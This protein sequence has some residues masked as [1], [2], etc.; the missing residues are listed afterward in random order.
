[1]PLLDVLKKLWV[2]KAMGTEGSPRRPT[3]WFGSQDRFFEAPG[4]KGWRGYLAQERSCFPPTSARTKDLGPN[5][6]P[7]LGAVETMHGFGFNRDTKPSL[8][9]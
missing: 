2:C 8:A 6:A 4:F 5:L 9:R 7:A 1:M 3:S